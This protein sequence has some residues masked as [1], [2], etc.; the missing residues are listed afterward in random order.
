MATSK[1][2]RCPH[3]WKSHKTQVGLHIHESMVHK[4]KEQREEQKERKKLNCKRAWR[5]YYKK[6]KEG[7]DETIVQKRKATIEKYEA[8]IKAANARKKYERSDKGKSTRKAYQDKLKK[9]RR[10]EKNRRRQTAVDLTA[11]PSL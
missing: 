8:T 7:K 11:I 10:E 3:C 2:F 5:K 6:Y 9:E 1:P 4:T